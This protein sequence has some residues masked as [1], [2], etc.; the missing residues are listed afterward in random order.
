LVQ[1]IFREFV[2]SDPQWTTG[3]PDVAA[4]LSENDAALVIGDPGMTFAR[5]GVVV[6]DLAELWH[7]Y[8]GLGFVFAMWMVRD[9]GAIDVRRIDFA[10][11]RDEGL[12]H[13]EAIASLYKNSVGLSP[14]EIRS[15]LLENISYDVDDE[16]SRGLELFYKLAHRHGII[17]EVRPLRFVAA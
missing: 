12:E 2:E 7:R 16:L 6:F 14:A 3:A 10:S 13:V 4:M 17:S 15:Y 9:Q 1:V 11:A 5:E 8:T